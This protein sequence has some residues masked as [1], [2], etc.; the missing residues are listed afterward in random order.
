MTTKETI[1]EIIHSIIA[2]LLG[3]VCIFLAM[4]L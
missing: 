4:F 3:V 1:V 2:L